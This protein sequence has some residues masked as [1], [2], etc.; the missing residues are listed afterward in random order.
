MNITKALNIT[1]AVVGIMGTVLMY[2]GT[3][4]FV[5]SGAFM[6]TAADPATNKANNRRQLLQRLGLA[7]LTVSFVLQGIARFTPE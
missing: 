7:L 1:S 5:M 6:G 4:G 2:R 3:F